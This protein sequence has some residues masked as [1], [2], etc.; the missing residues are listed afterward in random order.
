M[1]KLTEKDYI[2]NVGPGGTFQKSG[3]FQTLPADIDNMFTR[4]ESE[5]IRKIAIYF[6]GGLVNESTGIA[7]ANKVQPILSSSGCAPVFFVW[8]TGLVET[9]TTNL[10]KISETQLFNKLIKVI[11]KR[12]TAKLGINPAT[13]RSGAGTGF[14]EQEIQAELL[15]PEPF[16]NYNQPSGSGRSGGIES[17]SDLNGREVFI[18]AALRSEMTGDVNNDLEF[19]EAIKNTKLTV[20]NNG[21]K[22][23][24]RGFISFAIFINHAVKIALRSIKRF[25]DKRDHGLF[26]TIVEEILRE[27]Y[28]AELGAWVWKSMKDKA[29]GMWK[30]NAGRKDNDQYAGRYFLD[31][32]AVYLQ[33]FPTTE[34]HIIG[35]SAGSIATCHLLKYTS[36]LANSFKY[37][38]IL[39]MAPACRI[40]LFKAELADH[41]ERYNDLR[42]FTMTDE[43]ECKD[44][45][46]P[47]FYTHSLLYLISGILEDEGESF[48]A[49]ILGLERNINFVSPYDIPDLDQVHK[50]IYEDSK[51]R[52]SLSVSDLAMPTG[53]K[54]KALKHGDFDDDAYT[55][56][57]IKQILS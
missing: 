40:D 49:H 30:D 3:E 4:F 29:D 46:V 15:K 24:S 36:S 52:L 19:Q 21:V 12:V 2:I 34:V 28:I 48:D 27:F 31:K 45:L 32:L 54:T 47:Y 43:N 51:F 37:S 6:H 25:M 9:I 56:E 8:E 7:T 17:P 26:P 5:N 18:E 23:G 22:T 11:L 50:Y 38:H 53:M 41:P 1:T 33:K 14:S 35:H 39:F 16:A 20:D 55:L 44:K 10:T 57:S 42:I 13:G